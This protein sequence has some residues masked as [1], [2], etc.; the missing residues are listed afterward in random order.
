MFAAKELL[1]SLIPRVFEGAVHDE[2]L[3]GSSCNAVERAAVKPDIEVQ[4][5]YFFRS[6]RQLILCDQMICVLTGE[7]EDEMKAQ[8]RALPPDQ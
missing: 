7:A 3:K 1:H 8:R 5:L 6:D 2:R 4:S